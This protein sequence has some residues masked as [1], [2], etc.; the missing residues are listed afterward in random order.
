MKYINNELSQ[1]YIDSV[2]SIASSIRNN[3]TCNFTSIVLI[4]DDGRV[5]SIALIE[6][7]RYAMT[8]I[9]QLFAIIIKPKLLFVGHCLWLSHAII[10]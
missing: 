10:M 2:G 7:F 3:F 8:T 1:L 6:T 4:D 5:S 9:V